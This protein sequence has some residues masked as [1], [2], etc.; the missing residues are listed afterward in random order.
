MARV[1]H[2][3]C[4]FEELGQIPLKHRSIDAKIRANISKQM[5][6][7]QAE[8]NKE[9]VSFLLKRRDELKKA[10][11]PKQIT[12]LQLV[13]LVRR[14]F[15]INEKDRV[16]YELSALMN[17]T[18]PGDAKLGWFKDKIGPHDPPLRHPT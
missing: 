13:Y 16:Q 4:T 17:L 3:D 6:G 10:D 1:E 7:Q 11:V 14:F 9:L 5:A 18:Y 8:S 12:G 15:Q 2:P